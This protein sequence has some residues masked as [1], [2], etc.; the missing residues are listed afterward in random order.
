MSTV[1]LSIQIASP[2]TNDRQECKMLYWE[3][4][5]DEHKFD[6]NQI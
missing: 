3:Y 6:E 2:R 5:L 4:P 1:H